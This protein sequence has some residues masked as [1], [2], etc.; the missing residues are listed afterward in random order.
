MTGVTRGAPFELPDITCALRVP[1]GHYMYT[2]QIHG[3]IVAS[4]AMLRAQWGGVAW[5]VTFEA[6]GPVVYP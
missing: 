2:H 6:S 4:A 1:E 3:R 5:A